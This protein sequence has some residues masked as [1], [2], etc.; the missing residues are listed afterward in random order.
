MRAFQN[1]VNQPRIASDD[2][3]WQEAKEYAG[4]LFKD[5]GGK[6]R[7]GGEWRLTVTDAVR[8]PLYIIHIKSKKGKQIAAL[9]FFAIHFSPLI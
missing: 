8:K 3:A 4:E 9:P 7:P 1:L 5:V 6:L 2:A